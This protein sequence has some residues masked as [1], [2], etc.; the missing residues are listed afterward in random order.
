MIEDEQPNYRK[1]RNIF[2]KYMLLEGKKKQSN[3]SP[4]FNAYIQLVLNEYYTIIQ[5]TTVNFIY[6]I[7]DLKYTN[8]KT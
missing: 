1:R 2:Y 5:N 3:P 8:E 7:R 4:F 6:F